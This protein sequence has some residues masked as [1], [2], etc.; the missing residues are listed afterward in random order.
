MHVNGVQKNSC[1]TKSK[2]VVIIFLNCE[3]LPHFWNTV[4]ILLQNFDYYPTSDCV[5]IAICTS[6]SYMYFWGLHR[7][8]DFVRGSEVDI[9][10]GSTAEDID[11][12]RW[13]VGGGWALRRIDSTRGR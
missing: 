7:I 10:T 12:M 9:E 5:Y 13:M 8:I 2:K 6:E 4:I 3:I 1:N 11:G